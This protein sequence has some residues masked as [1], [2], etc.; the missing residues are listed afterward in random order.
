MAIIVC[1]ERMA[2]V[3]FMLFF[4]QLHLVPCVFAGA[5]VD[6]HANFSCHFAAGYHHLEEKC[7]FPAYLVSVNM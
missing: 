2:V 4:H 6:Q 1:F 3:L 7:Q 5:L